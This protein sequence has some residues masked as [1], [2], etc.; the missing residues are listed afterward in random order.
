MN[1]KNWIIKYEN[2][3]KISFFGTREK[4]VIFAKSNYLKYGTFRICE[5]EK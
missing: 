3:K 4:A 1:E 2:G 5:I